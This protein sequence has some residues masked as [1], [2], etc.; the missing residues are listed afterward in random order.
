MGGLHGAATP[1]S[2]VPYSNAGQGVFTITNKEE[3]AAFMMEDHH[4][5]KYTHAAHPQR[6]DRL[7]FIALDVCSQ[8]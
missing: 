8:G 7:P 6:I 1:S 4:Y 2:R 5:D 3:L